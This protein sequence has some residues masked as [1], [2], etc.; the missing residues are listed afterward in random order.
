MFI[1]KYLGGMRQ[2]RENLR[3]SKLMTVSAGAEYSSEL[4]KASLNRS[5]SQEASTEDEITV[6]HF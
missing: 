2:N 3:G 1:Y 4:E 5:S 6:P